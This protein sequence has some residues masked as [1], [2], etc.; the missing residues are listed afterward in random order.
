VKEIDLPVATS[1]ENKF[2]IRQN[3]KKAKFHR[4][5]WNKSDKLIKASAHQRRRRNEVKK[6]R[7]SAGKIDEY[8]RG[9]TSNAG[10]IQ[11]DNFSYV[12][13]GHF[14]QTDDVKLEIIKNGKV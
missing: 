12:N 2:L 3:L 11:V 5:M 4:R 13:N 14:S 10:P 6:T 9:K 1:S 7:T 8:V